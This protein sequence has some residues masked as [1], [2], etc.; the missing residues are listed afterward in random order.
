MTKPHR[1]SVVYVLWDLGA[2]LY[3]G[4]FASMRTAKAWIQRNPGAYQFQVQSLHHPNAWTWAK[5]WH[6][7]PDY[8]FEDGEW[9][10]YD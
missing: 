9:R 6:T 10:P 3:H 7:R 5:G 4:P 8:I 2:H 1:N